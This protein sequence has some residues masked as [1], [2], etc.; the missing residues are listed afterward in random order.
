MTRLI[1]PAGL[2][3]QDFYN[4]AVVKRGFPVFV[5]GQVAW[6]EAGNV[7]G[8]GDIAAQAARIWHNIGLVLRE[9]GAG[10]SDVVKLVNYATDR[11]S[12]PALH[13]ARRAFFGSGPY[14]ASTFIVVAG[15]AEPELLAEIDVTVMI[16]E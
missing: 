7:V 10:P 1:N 2:K 8:V 5:T 4:H 6:D 14:P 12:L 13:L 16:S 11:S 9:L 15:L 3:S